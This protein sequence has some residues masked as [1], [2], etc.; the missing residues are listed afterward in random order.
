MPDR[1]EK[2]SSGERSYERAKKAKGRTGE[3]IKGQKST[4][5]AAL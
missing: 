5:K 3:S 1:Y 2:E 4:A